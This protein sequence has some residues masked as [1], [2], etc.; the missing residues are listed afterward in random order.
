MV[1]LRVLQYSTARITAKINSGWASSEASFVC[2]Q[3]QPCCQDDE[4]MYMYMYM[5][6]A[7]RECHQ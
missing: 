5:R 2:S 3:V 4:Y 7:L 1:I 6:A